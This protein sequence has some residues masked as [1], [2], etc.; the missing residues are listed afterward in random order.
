MRTTFAL[1]GAL[2][3]FSACQKPEPP[4]VTP[5]VARV[6]G[7]GPSS[8]SLSVD[9]EVENPNPFPLVARSVNGKLATASGVEIGSGRAEPN[10][11]IPAKGKATVPSL[12][13]V[14]FANLAALAP[15]ALSNQPVPYVF[16]GTATIGGESLNVDVPFSVKGE[17]T[18]D[19]LLAAG[20][21]G[22]GV[23]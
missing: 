19:Q 5:K 7:V 9:L 10:G 17:L 15:F 20:L 2:M 21:R 8:I 16:S 22:F 12:L 11:S 13:S 23:P 4:K 6:V 18:R 3:L 1:L 14:R